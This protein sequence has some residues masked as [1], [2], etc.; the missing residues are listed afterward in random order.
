VSVTIKSMAITAGS[1]R[2][3]RRL[4]NATRSIRRDRLHSARR[5]DVIK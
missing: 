2:R 4:Q 3:A 5:M 1:N